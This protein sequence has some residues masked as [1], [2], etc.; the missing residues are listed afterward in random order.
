MA[1]SDIECRRHLGSGSFGRVF[2]S[3]IDGSVCAIKVEPAN[4]KVP[5]LKY[6]YKI[7]R[8]LKGCRGVPAAYHVWGHPSG[9]V[10]MVLQLLGES[11]EKKRPRMEEL[12][13][14]APEYIRII[15][16]IHNKGFLHRDVKP[17]NM[18][19]GVSGSTYWLIDYGLAKKYIREGGEHIPQ[20]INKPVVG[21]PRFVSRHVHAGSQSARRDD[22][23]SLGYVFIY[24]AKGALPWNTKKSDTRKEKLKFIAET[25]TNTTTK[26]LCKDLPNVFELYM[27]TVRELEF[28]ETPTYDILADF[29]ESV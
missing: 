23:E 14:I 27:N 22:M 8:H 19:R 25:K 11:L 24:L 3:S 4:P 6:E 16:G 5:Q 7:L 20:I 2:E 12:M 29:F 1:N 28:K 17:E 10:W 13:K 26:E 15:Q 21:T 9:E 18:L